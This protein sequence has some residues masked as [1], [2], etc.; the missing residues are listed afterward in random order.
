MATALGR[1]GFVM[2]GVWANNVTYN[3][4]DVVT[5]NGTSYVAT[6]GT[7]GGTPGVDPA[8]KILAEKGDKGDP[9]NFTWQQVTDYIDANAI[10]IHKSTSLTS[11]PT[12][13]SD[14]N[15]DSNMEVSGLVYTDNMSYFVL[16]WATGTGT[17]TF[18]LNSGTFTSCTI[19]YDI[20]YKR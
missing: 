6:V 4:L 5:Y 18:S 2:Q 8:W 3:P 10:P 7:T 15:I 9:G 20:G 1:V 11:L 12:T 19:E 16:D 13:V 14:A 17:V